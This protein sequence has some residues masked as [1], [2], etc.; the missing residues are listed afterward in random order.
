MPGTDRYSVKLR[1]TNVDA[2]NFQIVDFS[3]YDNQPATV[4][5]TLARIIGYLG[6]L[7]SVSVM[8]TGTTISEIQ[9]RAMGSAG[10]VAQ[11]FPTAVYATLVTAAAAGGIT[12][13]AMA[14]GYGTTIGTDA[15]CP[16]GTS[17]SVS[18]ITA[19][20]GPTGRGRHFLP[21]IGRSTV[22]AGGTVGA[23]T[24]TDILLLWSAMIDSF[25]P[26]Y[27]TSG[28]DTLPCVSNRAGT[29][30]KSIRTIRPQPVFSNLESRRR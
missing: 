7:G 17:I 16:L 18:E 8:A 3:F 30:P 27:I 11:P 26:D 13:P 21:F 28:G 15:L 22:S 29:V 12:L 9:L 14:S 2:T 5:E 1:N 6:Y 10:G 20:V 4:D 19:V 25:D 24:M 23:T